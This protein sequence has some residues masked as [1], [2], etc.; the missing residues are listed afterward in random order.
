[1][2]NCR[3]NI[4]LCTQSIET[5]SFLLENCGNARLLSSRH[6][7][8]FHEIFCCFEKSARENQDNLRMHPEFKEKKNTKKKL[9]QAPHC[10]LSRTFCCYQ[11]NSYNG[12]T[13]LFFLSGSSHIRSV[14]IGVQYRSCHQTYLLFAIW[15]G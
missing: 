8:V 11:Q 14:L 13:L 9:K 4:G 6:Y 3:Y 15:M 2:G 5:C 10:L 1:M 12:Q 7:L